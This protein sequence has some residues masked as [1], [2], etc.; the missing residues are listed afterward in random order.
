MEIER[1]DLPIDDFRYVRKRLPEGKIHQIHHRI[2]PLYICLNPN[3]FHQVS[4]YCIILMPIILRIRSSC[5]EIPP[6]PWDRVR[7]D[8]V[9][10]P[11]NNVAVWSNG[12]KGQGCGLGGII[13]VFSMVFLWFVFG[14]TMVYTDENDNTVILMDLPSGNQTWPGKWTIER[15]DFPS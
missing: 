2:I 7:P 4:I 6:M 11:A 12:S 8:A 10:S 14:F 15:G 9:W 1:V 13:D 3:E 5:G